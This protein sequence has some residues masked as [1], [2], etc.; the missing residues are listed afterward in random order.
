MYEVY[1]ERE[2]VLCQVMEA[3]VVRSLVVFGDD[4]HVRG[5]QGG[6]DGTLPG[7]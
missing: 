1:R 2:V 3:V 5:L 7:H 4:H 6:G